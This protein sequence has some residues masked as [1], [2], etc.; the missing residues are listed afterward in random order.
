ME[1][2]RREVAFIADNTVCGGEVCEVVFA[3]SNIE[4]RRW[5]ANEHCFGDL[6]GISCVRSNQFDKYSPG[7]V[8]MNVLL[9]YGWWFECAN[10]YETV[11]HDTGSRVVKKGR[12]YCS[13]ACENEVTK[14]QLAETQTE[15]MRIRERLREF[16]ST[17]ELTL[18]LR[19][20][21]DA[22]GGCVA[23]EL[24]NEGRAVEVHR[25]IDMIADPQTFG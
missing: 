13:G 12:L 18:W 25:A 16:Y 15:M 6:G 8:P 7:P 17:A 22:L 20:P 14:K 19:S 9:E 2:K 10:C 23:V 24:V 11:T 4:A 1:K 21:Q 5:F 3:R